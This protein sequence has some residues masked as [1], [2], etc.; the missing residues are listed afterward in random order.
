MEAQK[1]KNTIIFH[2]FIK[3]IFLHSLYIENIG[4]P[5]PH[6]GPTCHSISHLLMCS[7]HFYSCISCLHHSAIK[8][9]HYFAW[10]PREKA[11]GM[12]TTQMGPRWGQ[13][14]LP[15]GGRLTSTSNYKLRP[16]AFIS[17]HTTLHSAS[18]V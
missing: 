18:Y 5:D 6:L 9:A 13:P 2:S 4:L 3:V 11:P 14:I 1:Y 10:I 15:Q 16:P 8:L 17:H 7:I 12:S